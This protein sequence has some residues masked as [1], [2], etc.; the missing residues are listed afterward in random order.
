MLH[1]DY[2][3]DGEN[4]LV[5]NM[6]VMRLSGVLPQHGVKVYGEIG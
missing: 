2:D 3:S 6:V 1:L 5:L 4:L